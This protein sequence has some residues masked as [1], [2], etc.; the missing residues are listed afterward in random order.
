MVAAVALGSLIAWRFAQNAK[1]NKRL[2]QQ[3]ALRR[4]AASNVIVAAA[5][6]GNIETH[7]QLVGSVETPFDIKL[8]PQVAGVVTYLQVRSGDDVKAGQVLLKLDPTALQANVLQQRGNVAEAEQRYAQALMTQNPTNTQVQ[9]QFGQ[10]QA[11]VASAEANEGQVTANYA[12]Q[13]QAATAS[14]MDATAKAS[15]A[16]A[17][18]AAAK[19]SVAGA[20]ANYN[21]ASA[22]Y[23]R[24]YSLYKQGYIAPQ[25]VDDAKAA[26]AVQAAALQSAQQN[27][28]SA[29]S[30][31]QSA[32]AQLD[33]AK[34]QLS[35]VKKQ[36][37]A[38]IVSAKASTRQAKEALTYA[39]ANL[40]QI[41]AY[42]ANLA[43]LKAAVDAA[44]GQLNNAMAQLNYTSLKT[45]QDG[46]VT[47]RLIDPGSTAN[48]G[49]E[50]IEVQY[51]DWLF[52][53]CSAPVEDFGQ[54]R[55][56]QI[57]SVTFD[58]LP[59]QVFH[60]PVS[61]VNKAADPTSRQ[62]TFRLRLQNPGRL[63]KPGMYAHVDIVTS[64]VH[65]NVLV[66]R[67]AIIQ[68]QNGPTVAIVDDSK[69]VHLV[70]VSL[71]ASDAANDEVTSGVTPGESVVVL[72]YAPLKD[73]QK[74]TVNGPS[75]ASG[76]GGRSRAPEGSR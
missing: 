33:S 44:K 10:Q 74:V 59:G 76:G 35:I 26:M 5:K 17:Q 38:N 56:G 22:K 30:N 15:A 12:S 71:G 73:G 24:T 14:V 7:V 47:A 39:K 31:V 41:P 51:L 6:P 49:Q 11:A 32:Q 19:Q 72:S 9:S 50:V 60:A 66:P 25:D 48:V 69:K 52:V 27:V 16:L 61:S 23:T 34:Q 43:A 55:P 13:V 36:G 67:E 1:T 58:A 64:T 53:T 46:T 18:Q 70:P 37:S 28:N 40:S 75:A 45:P 21:D 65:A 2:A 42:K 57:A 20:Q 62:F 3:S 54:I 4:G 63:F 68:G 29:S 8:A